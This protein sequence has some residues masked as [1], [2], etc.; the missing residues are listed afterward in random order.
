MIS[1]MTDFDIIIVNFPFLDGDVPRRASHGV[2][3]LQLI[4]FA[5]VCNHITDFNA[6]N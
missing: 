6:R 5:R 1:A 4:R 3:I 2:Y